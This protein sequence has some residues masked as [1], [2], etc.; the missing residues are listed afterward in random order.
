MRDSPVFVESTNKH[1]IFSR[2]RRVILEA[3]VGTA[4][5][6]VGG[7]ANNAACLEASSSRSIFL[8]SKLMA[9]FSPSR[10][11]VRPMRCLSRFV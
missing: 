6:G 8:D 10:N 11:R 3:G 2:G 1:D 5:C 4:G 7:G 9:K